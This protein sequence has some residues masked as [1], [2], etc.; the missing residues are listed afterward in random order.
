MQG[1]RGTNPNRGVIVGVVVVAALAL[2]VAAV[3]IRSRGGLTGT[4]EDGPSGEAVGAAGA[5]R[6]PGARGHGRDPGG[7]RADGR[8][9]GDGTDAPVTDDGGQPPV[10]SAGGVARM[11]DELDV[12]L[13]DC[14]DR[15]VVQLDGEAV[16]VTARFVISAEDEDHSSI[17]SVDLV[18]SVERG[19]TL[20]SCMYDVVRD[21]R[22]APLPV[23][24]RITV[25]H[26]LPYN[27]DEEAT[28][29]G[30]SNLEP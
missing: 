12:P 28:P 15:W 17:V 10:A 1:D 7:A 19:G 8:I 27:R 20:S 4:A 26:P 6:L 22:F 23:G 21:R 16:P 5:D 2:I 14:Y 3:S 11:V 13:E 30:P 29:E 18:E 24:G 9:R 25:V